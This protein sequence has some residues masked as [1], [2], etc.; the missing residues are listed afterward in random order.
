VRARLF[1]MVVACTL[2]LGVVAA[3]Y[4]GSSPPPPAVTLRATPATVTYG[5]P[6]TL[7]GQI[8]P[9][10]RG[11]KVRIVDHDGDLVKAATTGAQGKF[12]VAYAPR[13]GLW[14]HA[15]WNGVRSAPAQLKVRPR[16]TASIS[17]VALFGTAT[18]RGHVYPIHAG[19]K[20]EVVLLRGW[21]EAMHRM[22][23]MTSTGGFEAHF[24]IMRTG[25][26][27]ARATFGDADHAAGTGLSDARTTTVPALSIGSRGT[28]VR[29]LEQR[30][31]ALH[32]R[33]DGVDG[34]YDY[35]TADAVMAFRKVQGLARV[36]SVD[37][38]VWNALGSPRLPAVRMKTSGR[39]VEVNQ[40]LQVL[41]VVVDGHV[42]SI[43][44]V[45]TGK[46][47]TPTHDGLFAV[48]RK[49]AGFSANHLYYP[50]YFDGHR[51][52]HGWPEVPPYAAS[53]GCTRIPMWAA[54]WMY[55]QDP[56]GTRVIVYH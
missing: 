55:G 52:I 14:V 28:A 47:S 20:V 56:V 15:E 8:T 32:Y 35:R 39:H 30:L 33:L 49:L 37:T 46:P 12:S 1:A 51:A 10:H 36:Y 23:T 17:G 6:T 41:S 31:V 7:S 27:R 50:S 16:I 18:V 53:H 5:S 3:G 42:Q 19:Q 26:Y 9:W 48:Y 43:L 25:A 38:A 22:I 54:V 2:V 40:T 24:P 34:V 21:T 11:E 13:A 29:I 44:H 4:S 45:S